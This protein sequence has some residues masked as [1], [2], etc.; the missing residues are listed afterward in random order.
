MQTHF[1]QSFQV[2]MLLPVFILLSL[3]LAYAFVKC[4]RNKA[5]SETLKTRLYT[6]GGLIFYTLSTG[7]AT[8]I[9]RL[10]KCRLI[11]E[12]W[13]LVADYNQV[14]FK[15]KWN[16]FAIMAGFFGVVYIV[17]IPTAELLVLFCNRSKLYSNERL[18]TRFGSFYLHYKSTTYYFDVLDLA[19]RLLLTGGLIM[20]GGESVAQ[21]FLGIVVCA[22]W[23][24]ALAYKEPYKN[25]SDNSLAILVSFQL[26]LTLISGMA[27]KLYSLTP[28]QNE[29]QTNGFNIL[30]I[31][32]TWSVTF[33]S[34]FLTCADTPGCKKCMNCFK[35][36]NA[37]QKTTPTTKRAQQQF[38]LK[39]GVVEFHGG[40]EKEA[41]STYVLPKDEKENNTEGVVAVDVEDVDAKTSGGV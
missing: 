15:T 4:S 36:E 19:R 20:M 6:S 2:H 9:F 16:S 14:C 31:G 39:T 33:I 26:M 12:Q 8:R 24:L 34:I 41:S 21:I 10:F 38:E 1:L 5:Y 3:L 18:K 40:T 13:Y 11:Q 35:R 30:L 29:Y 32:T 23:M 17:G 7:L 37:K 25:G 22:I 28:G 27:L